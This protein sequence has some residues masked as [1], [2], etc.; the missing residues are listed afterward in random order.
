MKYIKIVYENQSVSVINT[1]TISSVKLEKVNEGKTDEYQTMDICYGA[2]NLERV[3]FGI[4]I[5]FGDKKVHR[6]WDEAKR[7]HD[8]IV[9]H[10]LDG[11]PCLTI[12]F[13][14][15]EEIVETR[16]VRN[17]SINNEM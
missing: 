13:E 3:I 17:V 10:M 9:K 2:G 16:I 11:T 7:I 6:T 8:A 15:K 5:K 1:N 14:I 4:D 12:K